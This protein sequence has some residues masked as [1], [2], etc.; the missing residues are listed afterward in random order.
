MFLLL[1]FTLISI[2]YNCKLDPLNNN[3]CELNIDN[4][5]IGCSD[6]TCTLLCNM[7]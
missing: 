5:K 2:S 7:G 3:K 6:S 4:T 1:L